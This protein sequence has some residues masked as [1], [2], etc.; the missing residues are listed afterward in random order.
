MF[1]KLLKVSET[2]SSET[3][4]QQ[5]GP[6]CMSQNTFVNQPSLLHLVGS[7]NETLVSVDDVP[8]QALLDS[9]CMVTCINKSFVQKQFGSLPK[10]PIGDILSDKLPYQEF[11]EL[12]I[13]LPVDGSINSVGTFPVLISP[14]TTYNLKVPMLIGTNVLD[15]FYDQMMSRFGDEFPKELDKPVSVA[16]QTIGLRRRLRRRHLEKSDGIY[17]LVRS[18]ESI[19]L[20]GT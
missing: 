15:K 10:Y 6:N 1:G 8:T 16:L 14:D 13:G 5:N 4:I 18:K 7:A 12:E 2:G 19:C 17:G 11:V 20:C 9:G 3:S